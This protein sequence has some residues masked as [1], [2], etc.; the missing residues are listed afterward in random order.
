MLNMSLT[1]VSSKIRPDTYR[2]RVVD[3]EI[4]EL[5]SIYGAVEIRGTKWCG[6]TWTARAHANSIAFLDDGNTLS[7]AR[8]DPHSL[9]SGTYP[10][11]IDEWQLAPAIWDAVRREVDENTG[12]GPWL[13]T[14][15]STP[16]KVRPHHSGA[17][18]F[19]RVLMLP[20]SLYES[21]DST[22]SVSLSALFEGRFGSGECT[23]DSRTLA[24][25]CTRGGWPAAVTKPARNLS[26]IPR[27]FLELAVAHSVVEL[28]GNEHTA[29]RLVHSLARNLGTS[30]THTTLLKDAHT[31]EDGNFGFSSRT[32]GNY[33]NLLEDIFLIH[34]LSGWEPSFR[35]PTRLRKR[36][37]HYFADPS[38]AVAALGM[39]ATALLNDW[40]T[41]GLVFEN[42]AVRDL[43]VY[44]RALPNA[45]H[46]PL[47]YYR[48]DSGLETD[49]IIEQAD[50]SWGA[51]EIKLSHDKVDKAATSLLRMKKKMQANLAA[52]NQQPAFLAVVI[53]IGSYPYQREDGVY[54]IPI[55]CLGP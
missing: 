42:L 38:I 22:G 3:E 4:S 47:H 5:L 19:G 51:I 29:R 14:G 45:A 48:D 40:Q 15:S 13:L 52:R 50:G 27:D 20:M 9:L 18:R 30:P 44:A 34:P 49:V 1:Q 37:R 17:G 26:R 6:K 2:P 21:E 10:R 24:E 41:F 46:T 8:S 16:A 32:I 28:G 35:S 7:A 39:N 33:L 53:G 25:L 12:A 23:I 43:E 36:P 11:V 54:V 31:P 55:S